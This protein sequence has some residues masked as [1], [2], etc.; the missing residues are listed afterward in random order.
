MAGGSST[1]GVGELFFAEALMGSTHQPVPGFRGRFLTE[2][3][4]LDEAG[5]ASGILR[6]RPSAVAVPM[7]GTDAA[8]VV[9]WAAAN[10]V[11]LVP[12]GAGT[13][14][15]GGNVGHGVAVDLVSGFRG[16]GA[17]DAPAR[18]IRVEPGVTPAELEAACLPAGLHLPVD[19]SSGRRCTI[20]G[21]IANNS[22]GAHSVRYGAMRPWVHALELVLADGSGATLARGAP[23]PPGRLTEILGS[24]DAAL[25]PARDHI[26]ASWPRVRKNSSGYALREYLET[27]D[28]LDLIIGSEGTLALVVAAELRLAPVAP[29]RGVA[30]LEL[31]SLHET[32][33]TVTRLLRL[34]PA[35]CELLDRTFL[36]MVRGGGTGFPVPIGDHAEAVL[37]VEMEGGSEAEVEARLQEVRNAAP[38]ARV[39]IAVDPEAQ[40]RF[41]EIRHA[42]SPIIAARADGRRSMQFI[43]DGVVPV[44]RIAEYIRLL[45]DVLARHHL[46]AVIFGHAGDGNLHVNPLVDTAEPGW[47]RTIDAVLDEVADG[48]AR[49]G[50]TLAGEH[51]DGRLRAPLLERIW[52]STTVAAFRA[53][54]DAFDPRGI[55]NPGVILPLPGQ[56]P[57][58]A[59]PRSAASRRSPG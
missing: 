41:W 5:S 56:H 6:A 11:A 58:D 1:S 22:A 43:E 44:D 15:P 18:R 17:V 23:P 10:R 57:L 48:I 54:K 45:R 12:R 26:V 8:A 50:G 24:V 16:I 59:L 35:T 52:G 25:A 27:G 39:S 13:G 38:A 2:G 28:A 30:L 47:E 29:A 55:L 4:A 31:A 19:P 32:G 20:G 3:P 49:L 51:G 33:E 34:R 9:A 40:A 53:V 21:M 36:D 42:A 14:M 7:D 46:P 37:L